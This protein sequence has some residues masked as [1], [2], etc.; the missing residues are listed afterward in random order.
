IAIIGMS[1]RFPGGVRTPDD[2]WALV[3]AG[4]DGMSGFPDDRGWDLDALFAA[5]HDGPGTSDTRVGG[6]VYDAGSFDPGFFGMSPR[7]AAATDPQQRLLLLAAWEAFE[8]AGID[9]AALSGSQTGVFVGAASTGYGSHL[10]ALPEG[11]E[12]Y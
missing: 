5:D 12:G 8:H 3:D 6:F 4:G 11:V 1:C 9:P 7:E 10:T 2:L